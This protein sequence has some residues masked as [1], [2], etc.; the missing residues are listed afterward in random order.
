MWAYVRAVLQRCAHFLHKTRW[1]DGFAQK[2]DLFLFC[3][4][5]ML[6]YDL[7]CLPQKEFGI[8]CKLKERIEE[9]GY[10]TYAS[11][12]WKFKKRMFVGL[13]VHGKP[14]RGRKTRRKNV[15]THFL[16][17]MVWTL[18]AR[19]EWVWLFT[20]L[21]WKI[22]NTEQLWRRRICIEKFYIQKQGALTY[23]VT[24]S[25]CLLT[26]A[27]ISLEDRRIYVF[28]MASSAKHTCFFYCAKQLVWFG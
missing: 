13:N 25:R 4:F 23:T 21:D 18:R 12:A 1:G 9:N 24:Q 26:L 2:V 7:C 16:P 19:L 3:L 11:A 27:D 10:N 5:F 15:S 28:W 17:I 20:A 22:F 8:E 14:M 6:K